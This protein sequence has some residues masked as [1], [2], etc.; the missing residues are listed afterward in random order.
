M[1]EDA[2]ELETFWEFSLRKMS[3]GNLEPVAE[4]VGVSVYKSVTRFE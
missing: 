1:R 2:D 3:P 4:E